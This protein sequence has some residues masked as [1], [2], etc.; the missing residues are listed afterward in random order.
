MPI[1]KAALFLAA[2]TLLFLSA[3][4]LFLASG[5]I[6]SNCRRWFYYI[7]SSTPRQ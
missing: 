2:A 6:E 7:P 1:S 5:R 3:D 4:L